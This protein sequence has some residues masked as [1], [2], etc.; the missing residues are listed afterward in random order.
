MR[1]KINLIIT[2]S[3]ILIISYYSLKP[4]GV[5]SGVPGSSSTTF[6]HLA[7]YFALAGSFLLHLHD[8]RKGHISALFISFCFGLI[9]ELLQTQVDGRFFSFKDIA[10]NFA[11]ASLVMLDHRS[12]IITEVI[13]IEDRFLE[14]LERTLYK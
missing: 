4:S 5:S 7:A 9:I 6:L 3:A 12:K 1:K 8:N 10:V 2:L 11:G 13:E 14:K